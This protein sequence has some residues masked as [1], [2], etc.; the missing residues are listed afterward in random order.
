MFSIIDSPERDAALRAGLLLALSL[1]AGEALAVQERAEFDAELLRQRGID[2]RLAD[3]FSAA[4]RFSPG[5]HQ[6]KLV[7]NGR[8]RGSVNARF[9]DNGE[10]CIDAALL[11][12]GGLKSPESDGALACASFTRRFA[13]TQV[14]LRPEVGEVELVVPDEALREAPR[15]L[16]GFSSGGVA[17]V[18]NYEL[19]GISSQSAHGSNRSTSARLEAGFNAGDWI[20]RSNQL[21]TD[22]NGVAQMQH[23]DAYAQRTFAGLGA[24]VQVG[25]IQL[26]NPVL[27]G[28]QIT[29][30][31]VMDEQGLRTPGE[32]AQVQGIAQGPARVEVRQGNNLIY[33][34]VVPGGPFLLRDV[35]RVSQRSALDVTVIE[36]DGNTHGFTVS[37]AEAGIETP[38]SG[39]VVGVGQLRNLADAPQ[40]TVVSAGWT[41]SL[42]RQSSLSTGA[43]LS[44][45]YT[46]SGASLGHQ[47]WVGAQVRADL[48]ATR[49]AA[50]RVSGVQTRLSASQD[51]GQGWSINGALTEQSQGYRELLDSA[52]RTGDE[53][54]NL[55]PQR[56]WN[57][58]LSWSDTG[59]GSFSAAYSQSSQFDGSS[60]S[61]LSAAW[62]KAFKHASVTLTAERDLTPRTSWEDERRVGGGGTALYASV[63]V[64]LGGR[65]RLRTSYSDS[66]E[67]QRISTSF[68]DAPSDA[69]SYRVSAD[70]NLTTGRDGFST[71]VSMVPRYAQLDL[72]YSGD[73]EDLHSVNGGLRGGLVVQGDGVTPSAYPVGDTFA[74]VKVGEAAGVRVQ[75]PSGPVWTDGQ[76]RA[77]VPRLSAYRRDVIEVLPSSLPRNMD[78]DE[79]V[80]QVR[81]GRGAVERLDF[82]VTVTRRV[83]LQATGASGE[84]LPAG[85]SV[86]NEQDE[87]LGL[88]GDDATVFIANA[89]DIGRLYVSSPLLPR[90]QLQFDLPAKVT[91]DGLY[92]TV[93][94][95]CRAAATR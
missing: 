21:Y 51:L 86:V 88:V 23:I 5:V 49:S 78:L 18:F 57:G 9:D 13:L 87:V 10:L 79:G 47:P 83:L 14:H 24:V 74:V 27:S 65:K 59:L 63:S 1:G 61:R 46:S 52:Y 17:G 15:D 34:T 26:R 43:M 75:T 66:N 16:S 32:L 91:T 4:P 71:G 64:P 58:G 77:V 92:E 67:R 62:S 44:N 94:A 81:A 2:P 22:S 85:A 40:D 69:L 39:Y 80:Q 89:V 72:G 20:V 35:P 37:A 3:Y 76:G 54:A 53:R 11:Q 31:Q 25:E 42:G 60:S 38:S 84:P 29:G 50:E 8:G 6:V 70:R 19:L 68:S 12:A 30:V 93:P 36:A 41:G 73:G 33:T 7:V 90:C 48:V 55:R 95:I 82:G 45:N 28:A 56:Q